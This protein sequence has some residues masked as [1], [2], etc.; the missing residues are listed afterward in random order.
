MKAGLIEGEESSMPLC[1]V[2]LPLE[3]RPMVVL[4]NATNFCHALVKR[5]ICDRP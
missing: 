2:A 4:E 5:L 3:R 1:P